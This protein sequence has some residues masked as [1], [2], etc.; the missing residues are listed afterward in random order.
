M[1]EEK[2]LEILQRMYPGVTAETKL[3]DEGIID[4]MGMVDIID[5][6]EA[7]FSIEIDGEDIIPDNFQDAEAITTLVKKYL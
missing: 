4:S 7:E 1:T 3:L 5:E 2:V 6:L